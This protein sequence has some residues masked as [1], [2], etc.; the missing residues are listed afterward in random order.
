MC[1]RGYMDIDDIHNRI[2]GLF[3]SFASD[4][5]API[6]RVVCNEDV[7]YLRLGRRLGVYRADL[8]HTM[9]GGGV[10]AVPRGEVEYWSAKLAELR[11][12][13][14]ED[15][16]AR[17]LLLHEAVHAEQMKGRS[18]WLWALRYVLSR[19]F[20]R[21]M[22]R[23]AYTLQLV[24]LA[25]SG[26]ALRAAEW[27]QHMRTLYCGAFGGDRALRT[28]EEIVQTVRRLVPDARI[29]V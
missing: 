3:R 2:D 13:V 27:I 18:F 1:Y 16:P 7:W 20:R 12:G 17:A 23:E 19:R 9:L 5:D 28:F 4:C 24:Y 22:E 14:L 29:T 11:A 26:A 21:R 15:L 25:R 8:T 6:R 10:L